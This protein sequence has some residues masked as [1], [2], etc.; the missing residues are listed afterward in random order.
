MISKVEFKALYKPK[1]YKLKKQVK[2]NA[3]LKTYIQ[4]KLFIAAT[5]L[6]WNKI[7]TKPFF[8]SLS[9]RIQIAGKL[10]IKIKF[11]SII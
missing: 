5:K 4:N 10:V 8:K 9:N 7:K 11:S 2:S 3:K 6:K 1:L